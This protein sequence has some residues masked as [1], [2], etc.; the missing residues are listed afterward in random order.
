MRKKRRRRENPLQSCRILGPK[1]LTM[2]KRDCCDQVKKKKKME[3]V[4]Q[5]HGLVYLSYP[6][7]AFIMALPRNGLPLPGHH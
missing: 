4:P 2:A 6:E 5:R 3:E 1:L 7:A